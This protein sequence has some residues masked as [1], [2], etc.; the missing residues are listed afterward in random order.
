M[1]ISQWTPQ[2]FVEEVL[3]FHGHA[4]PGVIIGGFMVEIA[5]NALP[6]DTIFD[7][8]SETTQCLPDAIQM[9]TPCTIGNGWLRILNFGIYALSLY[10]KYN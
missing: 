9:L 10:D 4:A 1:K 5:R 3:K 8:F 2:E 7:A 6:K